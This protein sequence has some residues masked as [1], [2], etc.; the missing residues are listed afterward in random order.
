MK[1]N[2]ALALIKIVESGTPIEVALA[3]LKAILIKKGHSKLLVPILNEAI[4]VI[5]TKKSNDSALVVLA[6]ASSE[7]SI[8]KE[9][10]AVLTNLGSSSDTPIVSKIDETLIGGFVITYN[11]TEHD[12]SYKQAL[13]SL[14]ESITA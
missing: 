8:Q 11:H 7:E 1:R 6:S 14:Y 10:K 9:I 3:G 12:H 4:K 2:Y 5:E 13:K